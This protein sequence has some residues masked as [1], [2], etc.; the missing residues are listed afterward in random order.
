MKV[1]KDVLL[2]FTVGTDG[3]SSFACAHQIKHALLFIPFAFWPAIDSFKGWT[4][5]VVVQTLCNPDRPLHKT[6]ERIRHVI[7]KDQCP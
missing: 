7:I 4:M 1:S 3:Q 5:T 2:C 6:Q